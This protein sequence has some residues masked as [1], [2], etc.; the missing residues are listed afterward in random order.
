VSLPAVVRPSALSIL[1]VLFASLGGCATTAPLDLPLPKDAR[2]VELLGDYVPFQRSASN[3][4]ALVLKGQEFDAPRDR[5]FHI[6][7]AEDVRREGTPVRDGFVL[8]DADQLTRLLVSKGYDVYLGDMG[9]ATAV[10]VERLIERIA[11]VSD[12]E[13]RLFF[14]YSGEGDRHG[15]RTRTLAIGDGQHIVPPDATIEPAALFA[16]L[17]QV[18]GTHAVLLN[19]CESGAFADAA[20]KEPNFKG[21]VIAACAVGFATTPH[22]PTGT[23]AIYAAFFA[24]YHD[25]P[26]NVKNL[27]TIKIDKAGGTWTNFRHKWSDFWGGG[28]LPISYEPVVY[29]NADFLF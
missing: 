1:F 7:S 8:S 28:G 2:V 22:E 27:A 10:D 4:Y 5:P 19:A 14:A 11:I 23:S 18:K 12:D 9:E 25:D 16:K 13:T 21:V 29:A 24:L 15:L 3:R 6:S 26:A 20:Q 17:A